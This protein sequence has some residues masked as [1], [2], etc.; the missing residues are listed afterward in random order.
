MGESWPRWTRTAI[1]RS[2][3]RAGIRA[4]AVPPCA[5]HA[6]LADFTVRL[7]RAS[8]NLPRRYRWA[9]GVPGFCQMTL[10]GTSTTSSWN[11]MTQVSS[12]ARSVVGSR[13]S[14]ERSEEH[15]SE[16]QSPD[17]LVCRLLLEKK[18]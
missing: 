8:D 13:R 2:K 11:S 16:L 6:D 4:D 3:V 1:P 10:R 14:I 12:S 7:P 17:H 18:K 15:T 5:K 9:P